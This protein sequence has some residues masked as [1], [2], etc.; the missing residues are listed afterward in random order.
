MAV[1]GK[2]EEGET[3]VNS[4]TLFLG[5][6]KLNTSTTHSGQQI[7]LVSSVFNTLVDAGL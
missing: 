1:R 4:D 2:A 3:F 5:N 7:E 6:K